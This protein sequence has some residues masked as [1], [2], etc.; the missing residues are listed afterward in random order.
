MN[1][2]K[3][4]RIRAAFAK[5]TAR[6]FLNGLGINQFP[7]NAIKIV[8]KLAQLYYF[9][10]DT[11][12]GFTTYHPAEGYKVYINIYLPDGRINWTYTHE[13]AH[14]VLK[15]FQTY[16]CNSLNDQ[17][18]SIL[19]REANIFVREFLMPEKLVRMY[20]IPP[21]SVPAL[22]N[23]KE[24]FDVSWEAMINRLDE[25]GIQNKAMTHKMLAE[26]RQSKT[27]EISNPKYDDF[28]KA[29]REMLDFV[30]NFKW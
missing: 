8:Q 6:F 20:A 12:E 29:I 27:L 23:L 17:E 10:D 22:G 11:E 14:I 4:I 3:P 7:I 13:L 15:H 16:D 28:M 26:W 1:K 19:D 18:L 25:L 9:S 21:V 2:I 30:D 5:A 24:K